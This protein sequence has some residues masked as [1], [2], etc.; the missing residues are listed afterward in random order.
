MTRELQFD[1]MWGF[2]RKKQKHCD[3]TDRADHTCGD[4]WDHVAYDPEHRLVL[5]VEC[6]KRSN[7]AILDLART[8]K[9]Q[10][11]GRMPRLITTDAFLGYPTVLNQVFA[12]AD[13]AGGDRRTG[14]RT[15]QSKPSKKGRKPLYGTVEK[16]MKQGRV[17][18]V[19]RQI[20]W[21]SNAAMTKALAQSTVSHTI[22]TSFIERR[23]G[24]HRH[25]NARKARRSYR[26]SKDWGIHREA[27]R[28]TIYQANFCWC[29]RTLKVKQENGRYQRRTPAMAAGLTDHVW[30][31]SEWFSRPI[32]GLTS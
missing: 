29:V 5:G 22:N 24:T 23:N 9:R 10:M 13:Q 17:E 16:I 14:K 15:C 2:V 1:E 8:V 7:T 20:V 4:C 12:R 11:E 27:T 31:L 21:G 25:Q 3:P 26:F 19:E 32:A 30:T 6:G 28:F 18:R